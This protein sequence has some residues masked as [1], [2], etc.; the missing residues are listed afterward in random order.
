MKK[1]VTAIL[2]VLGLVAVAVSI[3][4]VISK[5]KDIWHGN[6]VNQYIERMETHHENLIVFASTYRYVITEK[7][8][9]EEHAV[10]LWIKMKNTLSRLKQNKNR[11]MSFLDDETKATVAPYLIALDRLDNALGG[12]HNTENLQTFLA[13]LLDFKR[14][15]DC[16]AWEINR[17]FFD[18]EEPDARCQQEQ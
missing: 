13:A 16:V 14:E 9:G 3:F 18:I 2:Q 17:Q 7:Q 5:T 4:V 11:W 1:N 8:D 10:E 6:R 15:R 12:R